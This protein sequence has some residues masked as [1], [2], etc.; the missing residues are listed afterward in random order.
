MEKLTRILAVAESSAEGA[1]LLEKAVTLARRFGARIEL[2]V[3]DPAQMRSLAHRCAER[4]YDE[5]A[6]T[7]A[8][9]G[10]DP[11]ADAVLRRAHSGAYDLVVKTPVPRLGRHDV[12]HEADWRLAAE[13]PVPVLIVR[14][15]AWAAPLRF[16]V[17]LDVADAACIQR[18]RRM[19]HTAGFLALGCRGN[20]DILYSEP[21]RTDEQIRMERAV[22]VAQLVRE[23]HVGCERIQMYSG[24]AED[25]LPPL[26]AARKYD[27]LVLGV[28]E[29]GSGSRESG[30]AGRLLAAAATG[31]LV[32]VRGAADIEAR[33]AARRHASGREQLAHDVK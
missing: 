17:A 14:S 24:A 28:D 9:R 4:G 23:F 18:S 6:L 21:E 33:I 13:S 8:H 12:L 22:Q 27:V 7:S 20:L 29:P 32:L 26:L 11:L 31:D 3:T 2:L 1:V 19:L 5:V 30:E 25:R 15:K 10:A 16:A